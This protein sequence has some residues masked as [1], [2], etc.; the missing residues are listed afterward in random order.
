MNHFSWVVLAISFNDALSLH[1][2]SFYL[3]GVFISATL[4]YIILTKMKKME[5]EMDLNR[6]QGHV[7]EH[8]RLAAWFLIS[9]LGLAGFP[10]TSTFVGEDILFSHIGY[11][12]VF[13]AFFLALG[14]VISGIALIRMYAR[15]FL[16]RP[17][18]KIPC[19]CAKII[20]I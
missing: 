16:G 3:A 17:Y 18:P 4:G 1:E 7:Y 2:I 6:F 12:Q 5:P 8:P 15:I 10:I 9:C 11:D 14:F 20:L 13:L 19:H